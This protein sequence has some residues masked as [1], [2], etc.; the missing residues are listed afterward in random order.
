F[1]VYGDPESVDDSVSTRF[2]VERVDTDGRPLG[3]LFER[4]FEPC[5][6]GTGS[7]SET[8]PEGEAWAPG[9]VEAG[10]LFYTRVVPGQLQSDYGPSARWTSG[11]SGWSET[12]LDE[13]LEIP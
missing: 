8:C 9:D 3:T 2:H 1:M 6:C 7:C 13:V 11:L 12:A 4:A 10:V 5:A